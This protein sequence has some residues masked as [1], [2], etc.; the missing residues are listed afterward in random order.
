[1]AG[2]LWQLCLLVLCDGWCCCGQINTPSHVFMDWI[3]VG[4]R[5]ADVEGS[6]CE[7]VRCWMDLGG[8]IG[9]VVCA[10]AP[11]DC[12]LLLADSVS[13]PVVAHVDGFGSS[14]LCVVVDEVDCDAVVCF[15]YCGVLR[16]AEVCEGVADLD[17]CAAVGVE[18][19]VFGFAR[20]ADDDVECLGED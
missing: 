17:A 8:K 4:R 7:E 3:A 18:G 20:G 14:L 5:I 19:S 1:M 9:E 6:H 15:A 12:K 10:G 13:H 16:E 2:R 11:Y